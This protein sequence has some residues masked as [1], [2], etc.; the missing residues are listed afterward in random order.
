MKNLEVSYIKNEPHEEN[1]LFCSINAFMGQQNY[2]LSQRI[3]ADLRGDTS[4]F[5]CGDHTGKEIMRIDNSH[6]V[7]PKHT[8]GIMPILLENSE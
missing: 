5:D 6:Y 7:D 4:S 8:H 1:N 3:H 2:G